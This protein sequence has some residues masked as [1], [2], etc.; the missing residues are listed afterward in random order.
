MASDLVSA[1]VPYAKKEAAVSVLK[2]LGATTSDLIND[3]FNF[4]LEHRALPSDVIESTG[5]N[6]DFAAFMQAT[7]L[8]VS[9]DDSAQSYKDILRE[10]KR[11]DYESL[12]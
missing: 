9:W 12:A 6:D 5:E 10:G 7:T 2:S 8:S 4:V 11:A 1:R 3:A